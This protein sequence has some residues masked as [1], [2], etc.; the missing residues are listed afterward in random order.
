MCCNMLQRKNAQN[1]IHLQKFY[2]KTYVP[3][4]VVQN[5]YVFLEIFNPSFC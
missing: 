5:R 2:V 3:M 4:F 1:S